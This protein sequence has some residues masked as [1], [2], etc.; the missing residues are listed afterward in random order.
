MLVEAWDG[1]AWT[2]QATPRPAG[3][4]LS[5]L[6]GVSCTSATACTAVGYY[7]DSAGTPLTVAEAWS[8]SAWTIQKTA[9]QSTA[10]LSILNGVSCSSATACTGV[11]YYHDTSGKQQTLAETWNGTAWKVQA[12]PKPAGATLMILDGVSCSS[13]TA[14]TAVGSYSD[15]SNTQ[16]TLAEAWDG[17]AWKIQPTAK[18]DFATFPVLTGVSC[19]S[20]TACTAVG[21]YQDSSGFLVTLAEVWNGTAWSVQATPNG[22]S[23]VVSILDGVSCTSASACSAVG[24]YHNSS[25]PDLTL[26]ERWNGITW[27]VQVTPSPSG[28]SVL[29]GL[30]CNSPASC[31]AVGYNDIGSGNQVTLAE[32]WNGTA[33]Q[34]KTTPNPVGAT[35]SDLHGVSCRSA[36]ACTAVGGDSN[37]SGTEVTLA[38]AWDGT[39][40]TVQTTPEPAFATL[41]VLNGVSC[42]S[43]TACIAVGYYIGSSVS[44][45]PLTLAEAKHG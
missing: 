27:S 5:D 42:W 39:A 45:V 3:A 26:A 38:E 17:T 29:E 36:T 23:A 6:G 15:S 9:N 13:A 31:T 24:T 34:I 33:W 16:V 25:G 4:T 21:Y 35:V 40:W 8:G 1:A 20:A 7:D 18:P 19:S 22:P 44:S 10:T 32:V 43:A 37:S 41:G 14:C 30:S 28:R 11:G 2:I 12:T